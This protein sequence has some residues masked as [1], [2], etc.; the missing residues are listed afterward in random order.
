MARFLKNRQALLGQIPGE[1]VF[2]GERKVDEAT[3]QIIEYTNESLIEKDLTDYHEIQGYRDS[4]AVSWINVNGVHD[5][6]LIDSIGESF[7]LHA[8]VVDNIVNTGQRPRV[9]DYDS[10][11]YIV[12]K[13]MRFDDD[14]KQIRSEQLSLV[15]GEKILL[16]FQ[17]EP[18]DVFEPVR[19]R[20]RKIKG[21]IRKVGIDYLAYALLDTVIDNYI[22]AIE[23]IGERIEDLEDEII[24]NPTTTTLARINNYKMEMNY[25]RK[26]IRPARELMQELNRSE[27]DLVQESTR[28]FLKSLLDLATQAVEV[29]DSYREML[30]DDL[31]IY[32]T[33]VNNRLNEIMKVLTIFSAIFIP[34]TF[35][36]GIYGT[37]FKYLPELDFRYSYFIFWIVVICIVAGLLVY[38]KRKKWL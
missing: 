22:V 28:P 21:R 14:L 32:N 7:G 34:L 18:G 3:I 38:F 31:E 36:A 11:L 17:E 25:L 23:R 2:V 26:T 30:S 5:T 16:T 29:V 4:D 19:D 9:E 35:I 15:V 37:N 27:S 6:D 24:G 13:M 20:I 1:S 8:L 12:L 10:Y 33:G